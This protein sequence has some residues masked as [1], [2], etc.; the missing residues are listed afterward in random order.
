MATPNYTF[1]FNSAAFRADTLAAVVRGVD[2]ITR[3]IV[4][5]AVMR[6]PVDT[7]NLRRSI[8][9]DP[10]TVSG[11]RVESGVTAKADYAR[12]V[13][14]GVRAPRIFP[15]RPGGVLVFEI[16]GRPVFARSVR[17]NRPARPF[18]RNA[19]EEVMREEGL[20]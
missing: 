6:A 10:I 19:A 9:Q 2:R 4:A 12:F 17:G 11:F 18:L 1:R 13:H 14:D 20:R 16:N 15:R 5:V 3:R 8:E 7:G